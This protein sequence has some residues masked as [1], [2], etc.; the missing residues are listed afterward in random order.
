MKKIQ[1][2]ILSLTCLL[3]GV[4]QVFSQGNPAFDKFD[5]FR[6]NNFQEKIYVTTDREFYLA[7]EIIWFKVYGM[8]GS[9]HLPTDLSRIAY[10]ELVSADSVAQ[11]QEKVELNQGTG[12]GSWYIPTN[13]VSGRYLLRAYTNWMKNYDA[14]FYFEKELTIVNTFKALPELPSKEGISMQFYPEGGHLVSGIESRVAFQATNLPTSD[15]EFTAVLQNSQGDTIQHFKPEHAGMGSFRFIPEK[16]MSYQ[17]AI[18][19]GEETTFARLP[20]VAEVG[21]VLSLEKNDDKV[22]VLVHSNTRE[23][24][25]FLLVQ[26]RNMVSHSVYKNLNNGRAGFSIAVEDLADGVNHFTLFNNAGM[27]VAERLFFKQPDNLMSIEI[28]SDQNQPAVKKMVNY[29]ITATENANLSMSV[30]KLDSLNK[31]PSVNMVDYLYLTSDLDTRIQNPSYYLHEKTPTQ[32]IDLLMMVHGWSRFDWEE[33]INPVETD[34][35]YV[36]EVRGHLIQGE[37]THKESGLPGEN[38]NAYLSVTGKHPRFYV[39]RSDAQGRIKFEFQDSYG[40]TNIVIGTNQLLDSAYAFEIR[41]AFSQQYRPFVNYELDIDLPHTT[42]LI[43]RSI[44]MQA[45]NIYREANINTYTSEDADTALFFT[46]GDKHYLL[47]D[48]TRFSSMEDIMREYMPEVFVNVNKDGFSLRILDKEREIRYEDNPLVL[49]DGVPVFDMNKFMAV[50]PHKIR[51]IDVIRM[52]YFYGKS[53]FDGIISCL[54]YEQDL[55]GLT[56][57][58]TSLLINYKFAQ[59]QRSFYSPEYSANTNSSL[60]D[61]RNLLFWKPDIV[62]NEE[63]VAEVEF[64]T[65]EESGTYRVVIEGISEDGIPGYSTVTFE[66]QEEVN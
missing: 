12:S 22:Q 41:D 46:K 3:L 36:P 29:Q 21:H 27:S 11:M 59:L 62:T 4:H 45:M 25:L 60:P 30:F 20:E 2:H 10:V 50:D 57:D 52:R 5:E 63:G 48:Y 66:V 28:K 15:A 9:L 49:Y 64:S 23:D 61:R 34:K 8:D 7:G 26:S 1:V 14:A 24:G 40:D 38:I 17:A 42:P 65:S 53:T 43:D 32:H 58:P 19:Y 47:D 51:R 6:K 44:D 55:E 37:I 18:T 35:K 54:S 31:E 13:I 39:S 16:D 33:V 56:I